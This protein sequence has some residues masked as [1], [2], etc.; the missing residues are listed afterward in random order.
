MAVTPDGRIFAPIFAGQTTDDPAVVAAMAA[1]PN[2]RFHP[3]YIMSHGGTWKDPFTGT[4]VGGVQDFFGITS[5][6]GPGLSPEMAARFNWNGEPINLDGTPREPM[7]VN[8]NITRTIGDTSSF[9]D[10][11]QEYYDRNIARHLAREEAYLFRD[12]LE[13]QGIPI[14][15]GGV[16]H[17]QVPAG[18]GTSGL[19]AL[20][21]GY[22]EGEM[23]PFE[24]LART[25]EMAQEIGATLNEGALTRDEVVGW[26]TDIQN[27]GGVASKARWDML[28]GIRS[29]IL[30]WRVGK[31]AIFDHYPEIAAAGI[32]VDE[33]E[34]VIGVGG[35]LN[36]FLTN[37][38]TD[39]ITSTNDAAE[40]LIAD[41]AD[42]F[43]WAVELGFM[44]LIKGLVID[45]AGAEQII[46]EVRQS[47]PY[48]QRFPGMIGPDGI[49]RYRTEGEYLTA[50][51][52]YR[53][54]LQDFGE[55][56]RATDTPMSYVAFMDAGI[57]ANEL[58]DR[59]GT[60]RAI[61]A[62]SQQLKDAFFVYA[63]MTVGDEDLYQA[64]VSPQFREELTNEYD[65]TVANG[66]LDYDT[67]IERAR[68][69]S[70]A[71]VVKTLET[72]AS[73][74]AT[75]GTMVSRIMSMD[76]VYGRSLIASLFT[77]GDTAATN[78]TL[79]L[80]ELTE[81]F[82]AAVMGSAATEA[83]WVIPTKDRLEEFRAAGIEA[84]T[85]HT[86]YESMKLRTPAL[87]GMVSRTG[88]GSEF[89][90]EMVEQSFLG[91]SR[92]LGYAQSAEAA[93]GARG[94]GFSATQEGRRFAQRGRSLR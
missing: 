24:I 85:L 64:V 83:G 89:G 54:V 47:S 35:D 57:D 58:K 90:Q 13:A 52:G 59:F 36:A 20:A 39:V 37:L 53:G 87:A 1:N 88:R 27:A 82:S 79:T 93:L 9:A 2:T 10:V 48:Q 49:R 31:Q 44:D 41:I 75:T 33:I 50:V 65:V 72:L 94:G 42:S 14:G 92:E 4:R 7:R 22:G 8:T 66:T 26:A 74:N 16:S 70:T 23:N 63:G 43:P 19:A 45:G 77:G 51:E 28:A 62:G 21:R 17:T 5:A 18:G 60:F 68:Q 69:T 81:A 46:A 38:G 61:Q 73:R 11:A 6:T 15:A 29:A 67:F 32:T 3:E 40:G 78:R 71:A 91:E 80:A 76:P 30:R 84:S 34:P 86:L 56:D 55:Y 25:I 12:S